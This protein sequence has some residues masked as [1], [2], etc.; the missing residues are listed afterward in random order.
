MKII[1]FSMTPLFAD[2]VM[3][4]AQKQ[5]YTVV[6]HLAQL[7]HTIQILCTRREPD[8]TAPFKWHPNAEVIPVFRFKQPYPE[9]YATPIF[10]LAHAVQTLGD[11]LA[12]ADVFY[13]HDGGFIFPYAYQGIP[14][15]ISLRSIL[16]SE[17]LQS[18]FLFQGDD[19]ILIS[20]YQRDV[21]LNTVGQ[22]FPQL[23]D[24]THTIYNGLDFD[25][26]RPTNPAPI[27]E[28]IHHVD[29]HQH[30]IVLYPH[31]PEAAKGILNVIETANLLVHEHGIDNLRVLVPQWIDV[32]LSADVRAFYDDLLARI[33]GYGLH[34]NFIFHQWVPQSLIPAYYSLGHVT[35]AIG[36]YVETFGNVPYE[37]MACGTPAIVA[38]VGPARE[39]LPETHIDKVDYDDIAETAAIAARIIQNGERTPAE[40]MTYLKTHFQQSAMV[41]AY[42]NIILNASKRPPLA[43]QHQPR[44][45]ETRYTLAPW[46]HLTQTR[47]YHDLHAAYATDPAFVSRLHEASASSIT[48]RHDEQQLYQDGWLVPVSLSNNRV[49]LSIGSNTNAEENLPRIVA[50]LRER[51]R[52]LAVSPVYASADDTQNTHHEYLNAA[53]I[54]QT[55]LSPADLKETVLRP[56]ETELGRVKGRAAVPADL[57][58]VLVD[59]RVLTYL[60]RPIPDPSVEKQAFVL[61]PLADIAPDYVH[62]V[63]QQTLSSMAH[64]ID[65]SRLH[66][67]DDL[68]L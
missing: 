23:K 33:D 48:L 68:Y 66:R 49:Y 19:L 2:R 29:R 18:A 17:T 5:L 51:V 8:A 27:L 37:S 16:F 34:E 9:P 30:A 32:G 63:T 41:D 52:V 11:Y 44:T 45:S 3:G 20:E 24:R 42:A 36:S 6:M 64:A 35:L 43:Y 65:R 39:L 31:R 58:I 47:A 21:I 50:A 67:R 1:A 26:F 10:N 57:D 12:K 7:G 61:I 13:S 56:M 59:D 28:H 40:T 46:L 22:F 53:V 55:D 25:H 4:G 38:R 60:G 54:I 14:T 15:V 62:P